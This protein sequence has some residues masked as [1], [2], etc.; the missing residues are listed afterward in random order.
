VIVGSNSE[1]LERAYSNG[2]KGRRKFQLAIVQRLTA[3]T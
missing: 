2:A 3:K 1:V